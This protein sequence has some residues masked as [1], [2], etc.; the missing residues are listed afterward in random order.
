LKK[1]KHDEINEHFESKVLKVM[2]Y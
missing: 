1:K 2:N